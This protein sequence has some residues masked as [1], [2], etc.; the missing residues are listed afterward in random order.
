MK[1][2]CLDVSD[3]RNIGIAA[4]IDAGKTTLTE[5]ILFFTGLI[6]KVGEVHDGMAT[7]DWMV[8][9]KERGITIT[10]AATTCFWTGSFNQFKEKRINIIDTPGHVDFTMEVERSLRVLDGVIA[11]FCAVGGVQPQS[12]TI[13]RQAN[14]FKIPRIAFVNKMDRIGANFFKVIDQLKERLN[15]VAIPLQIPLVK[16]DLFIGIVDIITMKFFSWDLLDTKDSCNVSDVIPEELVEVCLYWNNVVKEKVAEV[17][18]EFL[19][20]FISK[21]GLSVD[22]LKSGL[23]TLTIRND[24]VPVF[25][26]SAFRNKGVKFLLDGIVEYLP[27]PYVINDIKCYNKKT[28]KEFY[29][30]TKTSNF[31]CA[32]VFKITVDSFVGSLTYLRVYSGCLRPGNIVFNSSK[33]KKERIGRFLLMHANDREDIDFVRS[34]DIFAVVGLKFATTGDTICDFDS[35]DFVLE[36]ISFPEPVMSISVEPNAKKDQEKMSAALSKLMKEDPS[37]VSTTNQ[38]TGQFILSGM[39]ELHLDIIIDR[40]KRE[41]NVLLTPGKPKVSFRE[42]IKKKVVQEEKYIKQTGGR[43]QYA[44]VLLEIGPRVRGAGFLFVNKIVGGVIPK[45]Y[46]PAIE[47]GISEQLKNGVLANYPV[48]DV[49]VTL[50]D[51]SYHDVDSSEI[52]F[53]IAGSRCFKKG[54]LRAD[55][56]IL[57]PIMKVCVTTPNDYIGDISGDFVKRRGVITN[58]LDSCFSGAEIFSH[59]PLLELFNY[60]TSLRSFTQGRAL[61]SMEFSHYSELP[62]HL[63]KGVL[64]GFF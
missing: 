42:T 34:G 30:S 58:I 59:V 1:N 47:K 31:F 28:N 38:E 37:F 5:R 62:S 15:S 64:D 19:D 51:G 32:L 7:M 21:D 11:V 29:F 50:L 63:L 3:Y 20:K 18:S 39:G 35:Q 52:A 33:D 49:M 41:F 23:R 4:H 57:E 25:C 54:F 36:R 22:D 55:A 45:E 17:S 13:W 44:H 12:E 46:I 27:S 14:K 24:I 40:L 48:I 26:G 16:S 61:Y 2:N 43:G 53:K 60:S 8:Q 9:E 56:V 10:A 6:H